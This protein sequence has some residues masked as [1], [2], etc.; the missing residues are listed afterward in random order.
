MRKGFPGDSFQFHHYGPLHC[1]QAFTM[2]SVDDSLQIES[3]REI[4]GELGGF[5]S[6]WICSCR[7]ITTG[8]SAH[9]ILSLFRHIQILGDNLQ[10]T[11][12]F[13][14]QLLCDLL[15]FQLIITTHQLSYPRNDDI[16]S[17]C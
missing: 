7:T 17:V 9:I 8:F 4:S 10:N 14:V 11:V 1:L 6:E 15:N 13:Q 12:F 3:L 16:C 2:G 5:F